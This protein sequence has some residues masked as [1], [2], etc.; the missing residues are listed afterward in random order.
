MTLTADETG[1]ILLSLRVAA[2][3]TALT[4][5]L[6]LLTAQALARERSVLRPILD[7]VVHLPLVLPPVA[8][9]YVL[10]LLFGRAGPLGRLLAHIGVILAFRWTGA[11]LASAIMAFPLMVRP[12][13]LS[14]EAI[15]PELLEAAR[16]LGASRLNRFV[17]I[18]VPLAAPGLIAGA[19]LGF[20]KALGE[21]GAT[22]TFV[23]A[24]P[25]ATLTLP[26]AI[27]EA[28][29]TPGAEGHALLLCAIAAAIAVGAIFVAEIVSR[30]LEGR[31][32]P[33]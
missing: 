22:I 31:R 29:Q 14:I 18:T 30:R 9:G 1:A 6:A 20:A 33:G 2:T 24:I 7:A 4:L 28:A 21:F 27:W 25:G 10:L 15:D 12:I 8:T 23:A 3:A 32:K 5:P 11:A 17:R 26:T 13:R 19:V 16:T